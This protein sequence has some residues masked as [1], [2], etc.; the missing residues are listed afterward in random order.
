MSPRGNQRSSPKILR[1]PARNAG[2][3]PIASSPGAASPAPTKAEAKILFQKFFKSVGPRTYAAQIKEA[4][5]GNHF[6][7]LTEGKRDEDTGEVKKI[8][9]FIFSE[10]FREFFHMLHETAQFIKANP[11]S[12]EVRERRQRYWDRKAKDLKSAPSFS[13]TA[14]AGAGSVP[15]RK[16]NGERPA[17]GSR[18]KK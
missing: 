8:R 4:G 6:L 3:K 17:A 11:V 5:N 18:G 7:V 1:T 12:E 10:D 13:Q 14:A 9:L 2:T 15:S 16:V